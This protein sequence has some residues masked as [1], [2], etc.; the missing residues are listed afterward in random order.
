[1]T[2]IGYNLKKVTL[3]LHTWRTLKKVDHHWLYLHINILAQICNYVYSINIELNGSTFIF[4]SIA[5]WG[6]I[7]KV[8]NCASWNNWSFQKL[9][10]KP[11]CYIHKANLNTK[12]VKEILTSRLNCCQRSQFKRSKFTNCGILMLIGMCNTVEPLYNE[13][14]GTSHF[15]VI[16]AVI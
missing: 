6:I 7:H 10:C 1:M 13:H 12:F 5:I 4:D 3:C 11:H 16:F 14:F 15:R 8:S 2:S 9:Y